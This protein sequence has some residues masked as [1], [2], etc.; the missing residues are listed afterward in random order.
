MRRFSIHPVAI[1][2]WIWIFFAMKPLIALSYV[3]AIVVH[4]F[5]HFIVAKKL[6]YEMAKFCLSPYGVSIGIVDKNLDF[7]DELK[8][9]FAGPLFNFVSSFLV[10]GLWWCFPASYCFLEPFVKTSCLLAL[11]NLLPAYPLDGGRIFVSMASFVMREKTAKKITVILN[12]ALA[13]CFFGLF[14]AFLFVNFNPTFLLFSIFLVG[15]LIELKT[16]SK[17]EKIDIYFK[18]E[19]SFVVPKICCVYSDVSV[20]QLIKKIQTSKTHIFCLI[21][22]NGKIINLSEKMIINL[23]A[24]FGYNKK[25]EEIFN[26]NIKIN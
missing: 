26:K 1:I 6:G 19:K 5:G 4:E 13:L 21:L 25:L 3:C 7:K 10:V 18:K 15:G 8:I 20:G 14:V 16:N 9:A 23:S 2:L 17:Y 22:K 24:K 12:L 11:T